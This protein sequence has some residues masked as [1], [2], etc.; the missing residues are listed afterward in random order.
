MGCTCTVPPDGGGGNKPKP[1]PIIYSD[2]SYND[3]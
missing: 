3:N 1:A 2:I